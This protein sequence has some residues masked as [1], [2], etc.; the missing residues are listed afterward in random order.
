MDLRGLTD[1]YVKPHPEDPFIDPGLAPLPGRRV[2]EGIAAR[3]ATLMYRSRT[4]ST[5]V[6]HEATPLL[7]SPCQ[8]W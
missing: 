3:I 5:E 2:A 7:C 4:T 8:P 6:C 1:E